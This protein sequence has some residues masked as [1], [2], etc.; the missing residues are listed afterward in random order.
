MGKVLDV[1][2]QL[3]DGELVSFS[4]DISITFDLIKSLIG[5]KC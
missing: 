1:E 2:I 5:R 4:V 3:P